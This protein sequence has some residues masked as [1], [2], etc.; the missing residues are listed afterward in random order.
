MMASPFTLIYRPS[1]SGLF[2][3]SPGRDRNRHA[4][5]IE[6]DR[7]VT[8][9]IAASVDK[10][11]PNPDPPVEIEPQ[12]SGEGLA[13]EKKADKRNKTNPAPVLETD[14]LLSPDYPLNKSVCQGSIRP[15]RDGR[16]S[17][18]VSQIRHKKYRK[19]KIDDQGGMA[20]LPI[21]F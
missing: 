21:R 8:G 19:E 5:F 17:P 12:D 2:V 16:K 15:D 3:L 20:G 1:T 14:S 7:S 11:S 9:R 10:S 13:E 18:P 4:N 6:L